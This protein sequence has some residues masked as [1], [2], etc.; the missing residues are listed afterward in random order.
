MLQ[1]GFCRLDVTPPLGID[2]P[3]Y[4]TRRLSTGI[5]DPLTVTAVALSDSST[6]AVLITA[7]FIGIPIPVQDQLKQAVSERCGISKDAVF[8]ACTHTHTACHLDGSDRMDS[9]FARYFSRKLCDCVQIAQDDLKPVTMYISSGE[10]RNI[11]FVRRFVMKNGSIKTNPGIGNPNISH[12]VSEPDET[13]QLIVLKQEGGR[14]ILL[15]NFQ[16]HPDVVGGTKYS[17][18]YPGFVRT[19]VENEMDNVC[20]AYFNGCQGDTNHVNVKLP[21]GT[22]SK[23]IDHAR[24]MGR[25]IADSVIEA[26]GRKIS[27]PDGHIG[28]GHVEF[29]VPA[30]S[31]TEEEIRQARIWR[32]DYNT[33]GPE[34]FAKKYGDSAWE[35]QIVGFR[36]ARLAD[37]GYIGKGGMIPLRVMS[38]R[39]G[40]VVF[41]AM[42]GEPFTEIGLQ[43]KNA[44][45]FSL[46]VVCCCANGYEGYFPM[47]D[48]LSGYEGL[49]S[50]YLP[51]VAETIIEKTIALNK[52]LFSKKES[53]AL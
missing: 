41:S 18:D 21:K 10:A 44:S 2:M 35:K 30:N 20:C 12:P 14:E 40:D 33:L 39:F 19:F 3:G 5:L 29:E 32:Y 24:H 23:G 26:Y 46:T 34:G 17:A 49:N 47:A 11:S 13:M 15:V 7:D 22:I 16:V 50:N 51:G 52:D 25:V 27:L 37:K 36:L 1:A 6:Q 45:P 31:G 42:P 48:A 38:V 8:I 4:Y 9:E 28:F 43:I 53:G